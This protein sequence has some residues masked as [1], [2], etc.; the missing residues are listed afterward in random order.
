MARLIFDLDGT[1]IDVRLRHYQVYAD[2]LR[3]AGIEPLAP[4]AYWSR[5]R[6]G[7]STL[8][9]AAET[10]GPIFSRFTSLWNERIETP[11][12]LDMDRAFSGTR[13]LLDSLAGDHELLLLTL[14]RNRAALESQLQRLGLERP[15]RRV[16]C[17]D[18]GQASDKAALLAGAGAV[19]DTWVIGDSEA[20]IALG[21]AIGARTLSVSCGVRSPAFLQR[22]GADSLADSA[23]ALP[24]LIAAQAEA[25][26]GAY[27]GGG[28]R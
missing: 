13:S 1:L 8:R 19:H 15:F 14:R 11:R 23:L 18:N 21:R 27:G 12:Y 24:A 25:E 9:I 16:I 5:R 20:D 10:P 17:A 3:E 4:G 22:A 6:A 7:E 26:H 28:D 2:C